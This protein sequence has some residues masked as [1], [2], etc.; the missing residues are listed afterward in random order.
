ME[1]KI[2]DN[3]KHY[4]SSFKYVKGIVTAEANNTGEIAY[5]VTG[6]TDDDGT[7]YAYENEIEPYD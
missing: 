6:S 7:Y 4:I 5:K 1:F 2:G 3:I